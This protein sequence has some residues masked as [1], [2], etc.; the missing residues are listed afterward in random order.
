MFFINT[1]FAVCRFLFFLKGKERRGSREK[2][3]E[4]TKCERFI[5]DRGEISKGQG[6]DAR[7]RH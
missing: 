5:S 6:G 4:A 7:S 1:L 3:K 2:K